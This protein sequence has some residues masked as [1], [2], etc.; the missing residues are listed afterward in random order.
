MGDETHCMFVILV[1][2]DHKHNQL[3]TLE[4][5]VLPFE[6]FSCC[7]SGKDIGHIIDAYLDNS[8]RSRSSLNKKKMYKLMKYLLCYPLHILFSVILWRTVLLFVFVRMVDLALWFHS[9]SVLWPRLSSYIKT[10]LYS[11]NTFIN[12]LWL[13]RGRESALGFD[14]K[15]LQGTGACGCC[16]RSK[17]TGEGSTL[18][19]IWPQL[20]PRAL[21][22]WS[23]K[24]GV[25][26][27]VCL[28]CFREL[29]HSR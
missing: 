25:F 17:G 16:I 13:E 15:R 29:I 21:P 24:R 1:I 26:M 28:C 19:K 20:Y 2:V 12:V 8:T 14:H 9:F 6:P 11:I 7:F 10:E 22:S 3:M 27:Q 5:T 18:S 4:S 23:G